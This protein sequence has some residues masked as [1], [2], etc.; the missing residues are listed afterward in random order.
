[1]KFLYTIVIA[2]ICCIYPLTLR[3]QLSPLGKDIISKKH[4]LVPEFEGFRYWFGDINYGHIFYLGDSD[5]SG[6][7]T[8]LHLRFAN[9]KIISHLLILGP[10][11]LNSQN[12]IR[13]YKGV[14]GKLNNKY[15]NY[16]FQKV[17]KD[18]I[19]DDLITSEPCDP[20]RI[21]GY[22]VKTY[23]KLKNFTIVCELIGDAEGF[24]IEIEYFY[25]PARPDLKNRGINSLL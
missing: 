8:E 15:G 11:G 2:S 13:R 17:T 1:M 14:I 7:E 6:F 18:P 16:T 24:Y 19:I 3:A 23:W 12:C 22:S 21:G 10:A 4:S 25:T 5:V 20:V 9:K